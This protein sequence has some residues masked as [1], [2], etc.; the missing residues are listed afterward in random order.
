[1]ALAD[2][3]PT[4]S[5]VQAVSE[6]R[7]MLVG[8]FMDFTGPSDLKSFTMRYAEDNKLDPKTL[9]F[10]SLSSK[11]AAKAARDLPSAQRHSMVPLAD[12]DPLSL[13]LAAI[14]LPDVTEQGGIVALPNSIMWPDL[15]SNV[16]FVRYF[17]RDLWEKVL[18]QGLGSPRSAVLLGSPG[19]EYYAA[20]QVSASPCT[21]GAAL[22][23]AHMAS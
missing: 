5:D 19:S 2:S 3:A 22:V 17:Y 16:L 4:A 6:T 9:G 7:T 8:T 10:Q 11:E 12:R 13:L 15:A 1:M 14:L 20:L 18:E 21:S 23:R